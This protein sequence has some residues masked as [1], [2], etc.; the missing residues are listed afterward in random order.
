MI[1]SLTQSVSG[2]NKTHSP[3]FY[4]TTQK[5]IITTKADDKFETLLFLPKVE[6]RKAE[7]GLRTQGYFK[8]SLENKPLITV[9]TVVYN[10]EKYLEETINSVLNQTYDN[11][12]YIVI[13]GGSND[14][15]IEIIQKYNDMMDYWISEP[16]GG[17]Y[18]AMN[19]GIKCATG[20]YIGIVN[21]DDL[22]Y[23]NAISNIVRAFTG[24]PEA[25]YTFGK[26]ELA[27]ENGEI[28][29]IAESSPEKN[30]GDF[31]N[32]ISM[33][34]PHMSMYIDISVYKTIGLFNLKYKLSADLD[35]SLKL[36][37]NNILNVEVN[38]PIGFFRC[39]GR[40]GGLK[41]WKETKNVLSDHGLFDIFSYR[42]IIGSIIKSSLSKIIPLKMIQI[43][44]TVLQRKSSR[45]YY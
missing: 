6:G 38:E 22:I 43:I 27:R 33:A 13:D 11:I 16:D 15:T 41:T 1:M 19:K 20:K 45:K 39:G 8:T 21:S 23:E 24:K 17:I 31:K 2:I 42:L 28:F 32:N 36:L 35:F 29:G 37:E 26:V 30:I 14:R 44:K 25:K 12:E 18:D 40:S 34:F 10:G 5:P 3:L 9:I 4:K 7:G